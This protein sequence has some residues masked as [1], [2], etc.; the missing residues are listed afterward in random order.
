MSSLLEQLE[1]FVSRHPTPYGSTPSR[2]G[3]EDKFNARWLCSKR[4]EPGPITL[5][6]EV[7]LTTERLVLLAMPAAKTEVW[8][9]RSAVSFTD[10]A[11]LARGRSGPV[12]INTAKLKT[13]GLQTCETEIAKR[14]G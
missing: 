5:N 9:P 1:I 14:A 10:G 6:V 13:R 12:I 8:L 7:R 3:Q 2:L 11:P 4:P